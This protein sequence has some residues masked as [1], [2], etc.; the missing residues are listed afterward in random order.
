MKS[1]LGEQLAGIGPRGLPPARWVLDAMERWL[2]RRSSL[3]VTSAGLATR[4][5]RAVPEVPVREWHYPS[6]PADS[7]PVAVECLRDGLGITGSG[8]VVLYSGTFEAY[9]GLSEL[10]AAIPA[11]RQRMPDVTFVFVGADR[12]NGL[13]A[14]AERL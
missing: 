2:L 13:V 14:Q 5:A 7:S 10:I 3:V 1:S 11:V 4:V 6:A 9:Q 8:P 12:A